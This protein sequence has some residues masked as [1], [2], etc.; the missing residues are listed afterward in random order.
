MRRDAKI[1][2]AAAAFF[3]LSAILRSMVRISGF[4][5]ISVV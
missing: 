2:N 4:F 1:G 5:E 3:Q